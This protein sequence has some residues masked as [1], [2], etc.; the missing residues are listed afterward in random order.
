MKLAPIR[1][2]ALVFATLLLTA[3]AAPPKAEPDSAR[4]A[5]AEFL[6]QSKQPKSADATE[7]A[8]Y[9]AWFQKYHLDLS[10]PKMLDADADGDGVNNRDEF[11]ADTNPRDASSHPPTGKTQAPLR[12]TGYSEG[13]LPLVLEAVRGGK[14]VIK[15]G[16]ARETVV[17]GDRIRGLPLRVTKITERKTSDKEGAP[18]DRSQ[19][20][21]E[22][23]ATKATVT[24]VK[25]LPAK[26]TA[27][28]AVLASADG[29]DSVKV[30]AG[31]VFSLP[32]KP[33]IT[34]RVL[35]IAPDEVLVQQ[36]DTRKTW[37]L[38]R[39]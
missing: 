38:L 6:K 33:A 9:E 19:V 3:S 1:S 4:A 20:L 28:H 27:T 29:A 30:R 16:E 18:T 5:D 10:D 35:D 39:Q 24:L 15:N 11:L 36:Q 17:E 34:Y 14:A 26:S 8:A 22:D 21:L 13:K 23:T 31:D 7:R 37:T 12:F 2:T 25:G 32:G